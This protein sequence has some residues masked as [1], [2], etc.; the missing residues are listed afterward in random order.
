[1]YLNVF[2]WI[3]CT[4][5][6]LFVSL[7]SVSMSSYVCL[8]SQNNRGRHALYLLGSFLPKGSVGS[9][10]KGSCDMLAALHHDEDPRALLTAMLEWGQENTV[11]KL[12][13]Q[14]LMTGL[15][16]ESS[17]EKENTLTHGRRSVARFNG[18][19]MDGVILQPALILKILN[20]LMVGVAL[21]V[22]Q[23]KYYFLHL[24]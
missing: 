21:S 6:Q 15:Q 16:R 11:V 17:K 3:I 2:S 14:G 10:V 22:Y 18:V 20:S 7:L 4:Y 24:S 5:S 19:A 8:F 23:Y 13:E 12:V 9:L 1:M